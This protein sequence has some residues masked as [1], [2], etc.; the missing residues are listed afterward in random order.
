MLSAEICTEKSTCYQ[1]SLDLQNTRFIQFGRGDDL[2][3]RIVLVQ[4][5]KQILL[6]RLS[7]NNK[8]RLDCVT[9]VCCALWTLRLLQSHLE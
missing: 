3:W 5:Y 6:Q 2:A 8:T 7:C 1:L 9:E 4:K